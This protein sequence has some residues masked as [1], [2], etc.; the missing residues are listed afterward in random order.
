MYI[1]ITNS[2]QGKS[3]DDPKLGCFLVVA[4]VLA[5]VI[6]RLGTVLRNDL[7]QIKPSKASVDK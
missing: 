1:Q 4:I 7:H 3:Y 2:K 6:G 5:I